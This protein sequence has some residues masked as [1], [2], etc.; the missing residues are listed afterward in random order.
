MLLYKKINLRWEGVFENLWNTLR[1]YLL[2]L[3]QMEIQKLYLL[4]SSV[5]NYRRFPNSDD[6]RCFFSLDFCLRTPKC[7]KGQFSS[8]PE[9]LDWL[10][11]VCL[12]RVGALDCLCYIFLILHIP[13]DFHLILFIE[14][15]QQH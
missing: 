7:E 11:Q 14:T 3:E 13:Y 12:I 4:P 15:N 1:F 2:R 8:N 5:H 10:I 9:E 6:F